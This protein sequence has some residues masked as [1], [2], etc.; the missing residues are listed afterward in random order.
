M[1]FPKATMFITIIAIVSLSGIVYAGTL[2]SVIVTDANPSDMI[3]QLKLDAS[4]LTWLK[5][6]WQSA[7]DKQLRIAEAYIDKGPR[8]YAHASCTLNGFN[9][10]LQVYVKN[11]YLSKAEVDPL[12][13]QSNAIRDAMGVPYWKTT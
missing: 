8:Y 4:H 3:D 10:M 5:H 11:G 6:S 9:R 12:I 2:N 1:A 7:I 13:V